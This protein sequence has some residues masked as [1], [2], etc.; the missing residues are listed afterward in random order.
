MMSESSRR[1]PPANR[2]SVA[3]K[4]DVCY[5]GII[6]SRVTYHTLPTGDGRTETR[7]GSRNAV[8][9]SDFEN[10]R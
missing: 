2:L 5:G 4:C 8:S 7:A 6:L 1:Q 9:R 3:E 10:N